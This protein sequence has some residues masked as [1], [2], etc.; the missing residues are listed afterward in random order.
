MAAA[1]RRRRL[2]ADRSA[3]VVLA[4]GPSVR[5]GLP[6]GLGSVTARSD[7]EAVAHRLARELGSAY[8]PACAAAQGRTSAGAQDGDDDGEGGGR[9][10]RPR[11]RR[12]RRRS[13]TPRRRRDLTATS[14]TTIDADAARRPRRGRPRWLAERRGLAGPRC[15]ATSRRGNRARLPRRPAAPA[16]IDFGTARSATR[17]GDLRHRLD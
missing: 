3:D 2:S 10:R 5:R 17:A 15:T 1:A 12:G 16:D 8:R 6:A 4:L 9:R 11:R 13:T 7:C 14:A